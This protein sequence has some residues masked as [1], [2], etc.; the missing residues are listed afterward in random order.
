MTSA[1]A[2]ISADRR[3]IAVLLVR[4]GQKRLFVEPDVFRTPIIIDAVDS[5][6]DALCLGL[7]AGGV[8]GIEDHWPG[9]VLGK[10]LQCARQPGPPP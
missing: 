4:L 1:A 3:S 7:P 8:R 10:T 6:G 9:A 5:D 2:E